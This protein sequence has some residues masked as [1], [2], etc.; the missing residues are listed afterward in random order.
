M[1]H[2]TQQPSATAILLS[3][4]ISSLTSDDFPSLQCLHCTRM[5]STNSESTQID[6]PL[7]SAVLCYQQHSKLTHFFTRLQ[8]L[9]S[10][11]CNTCITQSTQIDNL[12][13]L[14]VLPFQVLLGTQSQVNLCHQGISQLF[15]ALMSWLQ[16][17]LSPAL[18]CSV[19]QTF[20]PSKVVIGTPGLFAPVSTLAHSSILV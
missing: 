16:V 4:H 18:R 19:D 9:I 2:H 6:D 12:P 15:L 8:R 14:A 11:T 10:P 7:Y 3:S 13:H 1:T 5:M 20:H 17:C